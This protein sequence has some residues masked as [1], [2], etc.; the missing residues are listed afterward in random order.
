MNPLD[1]HTH[2]TPIPPEAKEM[3]GDLVFDDPSNAL[4]A[5]PECN[6]F[7]SGKNIEIE[8]TTARC[9]QC[10]HVFGF[11]HDAASGKLV[12]TEVIPD[13]VE[14][15][16]L[17]S[18]LDIR[19]K[20]IDTTSSS[21]R[22]FLILFTA[23]WNL[24]VLPF[25]LGAIVSGTWGILLFLSAHL[26]VGLG[27]LWHLATIYLNQTSIS[28]TKDRI[29]IRTMPLK[30]FFWRS[31]EI[32]TRDVHQ[33]YVSE[34]VQSRT[35]GNPNYAYALYAIM[36]NGDKQSLIR[37]MNKTTQIYVEKAVESFLG[38]KDRKVKEEIYKERDRKKKA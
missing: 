3:Y 22:K 13:G 35:N 9:D 10:N 34:Y 30:N 8:N 26:A 20:W 15:L 38:I 29:R 7:I 18:E 23:L 6:H 4:L 19:L 24:I 1:H 21:G 32:K 25:A 28:I 14:V 33:L 31:K 12:A 5:C 2:D 37:G 16:K 11:G 17:R 36:A 27:L